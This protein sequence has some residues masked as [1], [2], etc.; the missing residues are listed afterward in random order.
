MVS[1]STGFAL[2]ACLVV[3]VGHIHTASGEAGGIGC[4]PLL[5]EGVHISI[6]YSDPQNAS[7]VHLARSSWSDVLQAGTIDTWHVGLSWSQIE[8]FPGE[9]NTSYVAD[10]MQTLHRVGYRP[11]LGIH[12]LEGAIVSVPRDLA[13]AEDPTRLRSG[14]TWDS[15][16]LQRRYFNMLKVVMPLA[17]YYGAFHLNVGADVDVGLLRSP[18]SGASFARFVAQ[19]RSY[20][21]NITTP[22]MSVGVTLTFPGAQAASEASAPWLQALFDASSVTPLSYSPAMGMEGVGQDVVAAPMFDVAAM[23][24]TILPKDMCLAIQSFSFPSAAPLLS[25]TAFGAGPLSST[26]GFSD[27]EAAQAEF[28][29]NFWAAMRKAAARFKG[30]VRFLG[31]AQFVDRTVPV[32][33]YLA[34]QKQLTGMERKQYIMGECSL[35]LLYPDG[36]AKPALQSFLA[37]MRALARPPPTSDVWR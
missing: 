6:G 13:D 28:M 35:G 21:T 16:L 25:S 17:G 36:T 22:D 15:P 1:H 31:G 8:A 14:L 10:I 2:L 20:I 32:C 23:M 18:G 3:V 29:D 37:G 9:I 4:F 33:E 26:A 27:G 34:S 24:T 30:R 12:V 11:M 19:A 7:A 5:S